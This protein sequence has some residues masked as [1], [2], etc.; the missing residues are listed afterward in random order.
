MKEEILKELLETIKDLKSFSKEQIPEFARFLD[1]FASPQIKNVATLIGNVANASPIAD[2]PPFLLVTKAQVKI[3]GTHGLRSLPIE[4]F[5]LGYRK[6]ALESTELITGIEFEIPSP[7]DKLK[8]YKISERKDLDISTVNAAF[9]LV[10]EN[11]RN[12]EI[13]EMLIAFGGVAAIPLRCFKTESIFNGAR[14]NEALFKKASQSLQKEMS[15]LGDVRGSSAFRRVLV[16]NLLRKF[17]AEELSG[18]FGELES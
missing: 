16:H 2:T 5:F 11:E 9:R 7:K 10:W 1:I 4:E 17:L 18:R 3:L 15:P 12:F 14:F 13:K 6:T 8:L